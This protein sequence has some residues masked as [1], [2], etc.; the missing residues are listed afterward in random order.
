MTD[1][2]RCYDLHLDQLAD[3]YRRLYTEIVHEDGV[4]INLGS[5]YWGNEQ[6]VLD[7]AALFAQLREMGVSRC[8]QL[9]ELIRTPGRMKSV[10][11]NTGT[12]P[13]VLRCLWHDLEHWLPGAVPLAS[14]DFRQQHADALASLRG[15]GIETQLDMLNDARTP[16][17]RAQLAE[18][19]GV[20]VEEIVHLTRLADCYRTGDNLHKLRAKI[21]FAMGVDS[22]QAK[23]AQSATSMIAMFTAYIEQHP[24]ETERLIPWPKE[25][26][27]GI[28]AA[29]LHLSFFAV[30]W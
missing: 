19:T 30:E 1:I 9:Y 16:P 14:L 28:D 11:T 13:Q 6:L 27:H 2:V 20:S 26:W 21:Y 25:V 3:L 4:V 5:G 18:R 7:N 10:A 23:A 12:S 17:Q 29:A 22:M 8:S 24:D 15:V